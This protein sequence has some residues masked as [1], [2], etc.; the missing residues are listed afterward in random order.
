M[1]ESVAHK[2][3]RV[4]PPRVQITYDVET[5]GAMEKK[6]LPFVVGVMAELSGHRPEAE[7]GKLS[8]RKF[9][10]IDRDNFDAKL[11]SAAPVLK[12]TV[13][14]TLVGDGSRL[15][16]NLAFKSIRARYVIAVHP[17]N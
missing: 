17:C 9:E 7:L 8:E 15:K 12:L 3:D 11:E 5:N 10:M 16:A 14:N 1:A 2:L 13:D 4:R 6:E